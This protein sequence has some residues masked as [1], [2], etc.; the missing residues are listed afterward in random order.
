MEIH[1]MKEKPRYE[2]QL[3]EKKRIALDKTQDKEMLKEGK[4][5]RC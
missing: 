4:K 2:K 5:R 1:K 3:Q